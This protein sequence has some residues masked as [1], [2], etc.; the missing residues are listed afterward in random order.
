MQDQVALRWSAVSQ[1]DLRRRVAVRRARWLRAVRRAAAMVLVAGLT[2]DPALADEAFETW[3]EAQ[4]AARSEEAQVIVGTAPVAG[5]YFAAG[6]AICRLINEAR[7]E[8]GL[9]CLVEST[10][11]SAENLRRL[12]E[13]DL[14]FAIV[15]SDWQ[16]H[17]FEGD[18]WLD[19]QSPFR[20]L[21][22]VLSLHGQPLT[23]VA[24][25]E[26]GIETIGDL[27]GR[28]IN[29]GPAGSA[30]RSSA[31]TLIAAMGWQTEDFAAITDYALEE[32][33]AA[34]CRGDIDA[35]VL[36]GSHPNGAVAVATD[37]CGAVLIDIAG[38]GIERL[39][40]EWPF[41]APVEIPGGIYR[42]NP[43]AVRSFGV[44]ATLVTTERMPDVVVQA[45]LTRIFDDLTALR[46]QHPALEALVPEEMAAAG[47][48]APFHPAAL[49]FF[50][51][52]GL[53]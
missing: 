21:R 13:G 40:T 28:R 3:R 8:H 15:Q 23:V 11:G 25:K 7:E 51:E 44:R 52:R 1:L 9:R 22:A 38:A 12:R 46:S 42:G 45:L 35:F 4:R 32:Q 14:D 10:E 6:G 5:I 18:G 41:Y 16:Y 48:T 27:A 36:P 31:E 20:S 30:V 2:F 37:S 17:A 49:T 34:L 19:G 39:I 26:S 53:R 47:L 24:A 50:R 43:D 33:A 29:L